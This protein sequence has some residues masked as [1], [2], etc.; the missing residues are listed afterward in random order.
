MN[1]QDLYEEMK[2][3]LDYFEVRFHDMG[4]VDV[5]VED[6]NLVFSYGGKHIIFSRD[7]TK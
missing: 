6:G 7:Y 5:K 1:M 4:A 2:K 3:A